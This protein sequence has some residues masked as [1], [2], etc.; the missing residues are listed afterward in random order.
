MDLLLSVV[1][2]ESIRR[3][4][5]EQDEKTI[6]SSKQMVPVTCFMHLV[7]STNK[8]VEIQTS[9]NELVTFTMA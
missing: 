7:G 6:K 1:K 8:K 9:N 3:R 5:Q 4:V 2:K